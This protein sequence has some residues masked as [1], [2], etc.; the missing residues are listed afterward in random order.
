MKPLRHMKKQEQQIEELFGGSFVENKPIA[1]PS[2]AVTTAY[3]NIFYW[4]HLEA[5][6]TDEFP[7]HPHQGF[8][9]VTFVLKGVVEHY[10]T[11][12]KKW[13][14]LRAGDIQ[15]IQAASG[16]KHAERIQEG[17]ELFQIWFDPNME[18]S[19]K[20]PPTYKDYSANMFKYEKVSD[21]CQKLFYMRQDGAVAHITEGLE[22]AKIKLNAG[23]YKEDLD[24]DAVYSYYILS[25]V[26]HMNGSLCEKDDFIIFKKCDS[27]EYQT[28]EA[29]E[30]FVIKSPK[31]VT[32]GRF[33]ERYENAELFS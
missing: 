14:P 12:S 19:L 28:K 23:A 15:V 9:I 4:A 8:E 11:V 30:V 10:D 33:I 31:S 29:T 22:V 21:N 26:L 32:Y 25:G 6:K 24:R 13:T 5:F 18:V 1:F 2:N 27:I 17:S 16:V 7:L 20:Q 3:S